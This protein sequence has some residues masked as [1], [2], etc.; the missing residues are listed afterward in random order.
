[1][2][3]SIR[4]IFRFPLVAQSALIAAILAG[5]ASA[6]ATPLAAQTSGTPAAAISGDAGFRSLVDQFTEEHFKL[7]P[8]S[9]TRAGE[10]R[11]DAD[12]T[13][14][15]RK[16]IDTRVRWASE[17]KDRFNRIDPKTLSAENEADREWLAAT[18]DGYL[19]GDQEIRVYQKEPGLYV[20]TS[21]IYALLERDFAPL[22]DR[23]RL[24]AARE[25]AALPNFQAA[26]ENIRPDTMAKV[27]A[28]ILA[29][30]MAGTLQF[31]SQQLPEAF[32]SVPEGPAK[33]DFNDANG[34]TIAAIRAYQKW[35]MEEVVPKASN[36]FAIGAHAYRRMLA[37]DDMVDLPLSQLEEIGE[38]ELG[39]LKTAFA[40]TA[41]GIDRS[42]DPAAVMTSLSLNHPGTNDVVPTVAGGLAAIRAYVVAHH[43]AT[44]APEAPNPIVRQTPPYM[45]A[46]T[47]ASMDSPGPLE[48]STEAY[49]NV[50]LPEPSWSV[51]QKAQALRLFSPPSISD[52]SVHEVYPGHYVQFLDNRL[53]SDHVRTLFRSGSNVEGWGFYCEQMMLDDGWRGD[54]PVYRLAELQ[55]ALQRA[56][57]FLAGI[58]MH[59]RGMT[60][61]EAAA[62]FVQNA[63][64]TPHNAMVEALRGTQDPGYLRYQLGKLMIMKLRDD[65]RSKEGDAFDLGRFHDDFLRYGAIPIKLIRRGMLGSDGPLLGSK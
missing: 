6:A 7:N 34:K 29:Q 5:L 44:I 46:T 38:R 52:I 16:G 20:P 48:K 17:W 28:E 14:L 65:V 41:A 49:F 27:A 31:F 30:E 47:F 43:L 2:R 4:A 8:E 58:R 56:C 55:M 50:T 21:G 24:V 36:N 54:D 33:A 57:R 23:M 42:R 15:T 62:F 13:D 3:H 22:Q 39:R 45:R 61:D 11:F 60:V 1:M 59:T 35:L 53:N 32:A 37:D 63:Y 51:E 9:A 40:A 26:R 12:A 10:H 64:M 25:R 18:C 19:L